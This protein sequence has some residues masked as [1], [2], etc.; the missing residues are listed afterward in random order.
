[1]RTMRIAAL[2]SGVFLCARLTAQ[3]KP[4]PG[5]LAAIGQIKAIDNHAHPPRILAPGEPRDLEID[6]LISAMGPNFQNYPP[7]LRLRGNNPQSIPAWRA[8]FQYPYRDFLPAHIAE[9]I[10]SKQKVMHDQG[11]GYP[12]WVLD[13]IGIETMLANRIAMGRGLTAPRF[14]WSRF[15]VHGYC[16]P[17]ANDAILARP[18]VT[19]AHPSRCMPLAARPLEPGACRSGQARTADRRASGA[20][21]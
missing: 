19:E 10:K 21:R 1:M 20:D 7:P 4:D 16:H 13:R 17:S 3:E 12:A 8:F 5:L 15:R 2:L 18:C 6:A 11:D 14:R 9:L